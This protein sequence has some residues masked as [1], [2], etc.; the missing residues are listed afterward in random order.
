MVIGVTTSGR[1]DN[2][3]EARS[4]VLDVEGVDVASLTVNSIQFRYKT[5][6]AESEVL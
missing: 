4:K 3:F 6:V 1:E 5:V 2:S